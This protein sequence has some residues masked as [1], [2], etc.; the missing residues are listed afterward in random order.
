MVG[1]SFF[2]G[3]AM[4][5]SGSRTKSSLS[6]GPPVPDDILDDLCFRFLINI[7]DDQ[8]IYILTLQNVLSPFDIENSDFSIYL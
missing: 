3:A 1:N 2:S 8:V 5:S 4:E 7:P 6:F